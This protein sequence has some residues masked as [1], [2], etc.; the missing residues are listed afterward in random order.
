MH[1][2]PACMGEKKIFNGKDFVDCKYCEGTGKVN[3]KKL[4]DFDPIS[5]IEM[6]YDDIE[7]TEW[8]KY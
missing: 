1:E 7:D 8:T 6:T 2:C 4:E 5:D 3:S